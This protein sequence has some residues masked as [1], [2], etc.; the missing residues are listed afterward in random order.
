MPDQIEFE[1]IDLTTR[2]W[3][4]RRHVF[5]W[6]W[7]MRCRVRILVVTDGTGSFDG[8]ASFGLG[9]VLDIVRD[10]LWPH[11]SFSFTTAH[12]GPGAADK[13]HFRFD[14]EDLSQYHQ[15]WLFGVARSPSGISHAELRAISKFMDA[16]GGIFAT[17]D[18]EDLG[19]QL[20]AEVPR[21][22]SMRRWYWPDPGPNGE[23]VAPNQI[24][25]DRHD[26]L[27]DD[28]T[29][30]AVESSQTDKVPQ[31]ISP[32]FYSSHIPGGISGRVAKY[33]HPI[34]CS[35]EGVITHLPDHMHEGLIEVPDDLTQ[36]FTFEGYAV[37][38]YPSV[39]G[40]QQPPE[41]IADA[42]NF[43]TGDDFGVLGAYDG[44]RVDVGRV[45]VD[46]T[47]HHWFNINM[48]PYLNASDPGHPTYDA[49]VVP[50]WEEIKAYFRNVAA[51][52]APPRMQSCLRKSGSLYTLGHH[53]IAMTIQDVGRLR[54]PLSYYW[55]L[56]VFARDAL[57]RVA[58]R[59]Q[60]IEWI[61]QLRLVPELE[62]FI[63]PWDLR[64]KEP[65]GL[66]PV[67]FVEIE[68]FVDVA[69]G[70]AVHALATKLGD[71]SQGVVEKLL[72]DDNAIN[73]IAR[74][75]AREAMAI[76]VDQ[77]RSSCDWVEGLGK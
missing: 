6:R 51:W 11:A 33:P 29:T 27:T 21:V 55:Q 69:L 39:R 10:D 61:R 5:D 32:Q 48:N 17:G 47:W 64:I 54:D 15:I 2:D 23:P 76:A 7:W 62:S 3:D 42:T 20:C 13:V 72:R 67:P 9:K 68:D 18:H 59:C 65:P 74:A 49:A 46:A 40:H 53:E 38:E 52:L 71:R 12:R 8:V 14:D 57:G 1:R 60:S 66:D 44:H 36:V 22:R 28:P 37:T 58:G 19:G 26:T 41:V 25:A 35:P 30:V 56:G 75:G 24:G 70:G 16:G 50:K 43:V 31:V 73:E 4:F 63:D 34:L 45:V 77:Y